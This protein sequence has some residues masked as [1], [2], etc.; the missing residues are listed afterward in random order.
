LFSAKVG[1]EYSGSS[2][3]RRDW[4]SRAPERVA[5]STFQQDHKQEFLTILAAS[6]HH[7]HLLLLQQQQ[8]KSYTARGGKQCY[9]SKKLEESRT[10][11]IASS[12][13][14]NPNLSIFCVEKKQDKRTNEQTVRLL[15]LLSRVYCILLPGDG[16]TVTKPNLKAPAAS[17][18]SLRL[19]THTKT[20]TLHHHHHKKQHSTKTAFFFFFVVA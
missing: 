17:N 4:C 20:T 7:H 3:S 5:Q 6:C 14:Q 15:H 13:V 18:F 16:K 10:K 2:P 12:L 1:E 8:T 11:S 9:S 19:S